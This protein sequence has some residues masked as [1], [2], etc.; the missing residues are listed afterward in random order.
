M[1][2]IH[3]LISFIMILLHKS[4]LL[5][6]ALLLVLYL[7]PGTLHAQSDAI[8]DAFN[9]DTSQYSIDLDLVLDGGPPKDGIPALTNPDFVSASE[10]TSPDDI[11]GIFVDINDD[12]RFYPYNILVWHEIVNDV[13]GGEAVA[14]TFCPLCGSAMLFS[15]EHEGEVLEFGVSGALYQSNMLM[16]NKSTHS[17]WS[18][19]M[20]EAVVGEHTGTQLE[21]LPFQL[22]EFSEVRRQYS[23]VKVLSKETGYRRN[24]S[25]YPYGDY[26]SNMSLVFP[27]IREDDRFHPKKM[28]YVFDAGARTVALDPEMLPENG[29]RQK[30]INGQEYEIQREGDV[31]E[32]YQTLDDREQRLPGYWEMWFSWFVHHGEDGLVLS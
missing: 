20:R 15:R 21:M 10:S 4:R 32:V 9:T 17:F 25:R 2:R 29:T 22:L 16:Y 6:A 14:V 12:R 19:A 7:A 23:Y 1:S 24:Y 8:F 5:P 18:Q 11:R 3:S 26:E 30:E 28:M 27:V 31:I 13:V